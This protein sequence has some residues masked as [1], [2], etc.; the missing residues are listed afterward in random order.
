MD[1]RLD[2]SE[3]RFCETEILD[4]MP[5]V[6]LSGWEGKNPGMRRRDRKSATILVHWECW[7]TMA[8]ILRNH[9]EDEAKHHAETS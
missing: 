8:S 7:E 2:G 3:C 9:M 6:T 1:M 5:I 4:E